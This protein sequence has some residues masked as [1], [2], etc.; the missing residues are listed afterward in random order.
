[1][2]LSYRNQ[3]TD[4]LCKSIDCFLYERG[5]GRKRVKPLF[6]PV[7]YKF[8]INKKNTWLWNKNVNE[9]N[10]TFR[11]HPGHSPFNL[12]STSM[13]KLICWMQ[14]Q[15]TTKT[16]D[17]H[18]WSYLVSLLLNLSTTNKL[19]LIRKKLAYIRLH[20]ETLLHRLCTQTLYYSGFDLTFKKWFVTFP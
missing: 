3:S 13:G 5:I 18:N 12:R 10:K 11:R 19:M 17:G 2:S 4:L 14:L 8:K 6:T 16:Y 9:L 1:M 15:L 20:V 7:K